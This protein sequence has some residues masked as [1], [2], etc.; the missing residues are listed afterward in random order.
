[1]P[2]LDVDVVAF[3][4][5]NDQLNSSIKT[6]M[7]IL[8]QINGIVQRVPSSLN[9]AALVPYQA[10][11]QRWNAAYGES[12]S[13]VTQIHASAVECREIIVQGDATGGSI[14]GGS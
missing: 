4:A 14:M 9:E 10:R 5:A 8:E 12:Q 3:E 7:D 6:V 2:Q 13:E 11:Q 1:M